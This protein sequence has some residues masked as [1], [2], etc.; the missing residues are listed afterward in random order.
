MKTITVYQHGQIVK[1]SYWDYIMQKVKEHRIRNTSRSDD[2]HPSLSEV[3]NRKVPV[4]C[5]GWKE[6]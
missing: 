3:E 5:V 4:K 6:E 1:M 2:L